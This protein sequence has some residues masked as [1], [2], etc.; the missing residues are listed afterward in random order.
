MW[1]E[2]IGEEEVVVDKL[3]SQCER[4]GK[5]PKLVDWFE[6]LG[7]LKLLPETPPKRIKLLEFEPIFIH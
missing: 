6:R 2:K 1:S 7:F 3:Y 5:M 4:G